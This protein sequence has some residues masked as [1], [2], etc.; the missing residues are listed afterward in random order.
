MAL[1]RGKAGAATPPPPFVTRSAGSGW[2]QEKQTDGWPGE[3]IVFMPHA[4]QRTCTGGG[5]LVLMGSCPSAGA[6]MNGAGG[7]GAT[8]YGGAGVGGAC[9]PMANNGC[10]WGAGC[11]GGGP[12]AA[13]SGITGP[14]AA[15][16]AGSGESPCIPYPPGGGGAP[17]GGP[18]AGGP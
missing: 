9:A 1:V 3:A 10:G 15:A 18:P 17:Y 4:G 7:G 11:C 2:P 8:P 16:I 6:G 13:P 12:K 14:V 5:A